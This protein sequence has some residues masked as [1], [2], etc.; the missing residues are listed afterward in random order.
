MEFRLPPRYM[1][2]HS[3][4]YRPFPSNTL[5]IRH[6]NSILISHPYLPRC[7]LRLINPISTCKRSLHILYLLIPSRRTGYLLRIIYLPRNMKHR[8]NP[9]IRSHSNCIHRICSSM[10]TDIFLRCHSNYKSFIRYPLY[11]DYP[12]RMNLRWLLSR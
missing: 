12:S 11:W 8:S 6:N 3:N 2:H 4:H 9:L 5:H 7:K 1:P 10:R